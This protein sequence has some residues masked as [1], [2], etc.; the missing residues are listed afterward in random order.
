MFD[1]KEIPKIDAHIH[2][3]PDDVIAANS[4]YGD[5]FVDYGSVEDYLQLMKTYNIEGAFIMPFN[6]PYMLS[7]DFAVESVHANLREMVRQGAGKLCCFADV[8][9]RKEIGETLTELERTLGEEGFIGIK[10]HP[11]NTGYP[12]DGE[13]YDAIF[14]YA[15][16]NGILVEVHSYPREHLRD[17]VSS[18]GRIK[19]VLEK[20]PDLKMS[21]AHMGGF[22]YEALY[23]IN[24]YFNISA[25]LPDLVNRY[26]IE[27]ANRILR[28]IGTE[29]LVFAS[30]YPDSRCLKPAEIY[31]TYF[32][33][34]NQMDFTREE[35]EAI[36]KYNALKMTGI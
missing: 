12:V 32:A 7:M 11:S 35:A 10:I 29:K 31:D 28:S 36:C 25:I 4:G 14:R 17:D 20:Y 19:K 15:S 9:I 3:L 34:L 2:L 16:D 27:K 23:G 13:Y 21:I 5:P 30:D 22:Q 1:W 26:G 24:A 18:P 33:V 8:D 6:D